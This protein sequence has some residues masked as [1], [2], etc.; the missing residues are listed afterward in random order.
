MAP[1]KLA[2]LFEPITS[3]LSAL[4]LAIRD[5]ALPLSD[6]PLLL[7]RAVCSLR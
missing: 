6:R 2:T 3:I 7:A 1:R 4:S 5:Y